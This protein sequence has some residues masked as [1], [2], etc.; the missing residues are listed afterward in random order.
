MGLVIC[1]LFTNK[2]LLTGL[3]KLEPSAY[4]YNNFYELV[5]INEETY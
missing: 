2:Y 5:V 1:V 3:Q 4:R